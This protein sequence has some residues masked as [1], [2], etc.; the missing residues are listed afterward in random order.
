EIE[1]PDPR[2]MLE[3]MQTYGGF[4]VIDGER[5]EVNF[6]S[7]ANVEMKFDDDK[8]EIK[9]QQVV[10]R[11][12]V[13][14]PSGIVAQRSV[15]LDPDSPP[16]GWERGRGPENNPVGNGPPTW[17]NNRHDRDDDDDERGNRGDRRDRDDDDDDDD[18]D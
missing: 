8:L 5:I 12:M 3:F 9:A 7:S 1:A 17:A 4:P 14:G 10:L 11:I 15:T 13:V 2:E 18:D 6:R 16:P